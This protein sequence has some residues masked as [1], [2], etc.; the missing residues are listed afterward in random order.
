M[1]ETC[2]TC[3]FWLRDNQAFEGGSWR[4]CFRATSTDH[5]YEPRGRMFI[6]AVDDY[7][8]ALVTA[9]DFGCTEWRTIGDGIPVAIS[10]FGHLGFGYPG[11]TGQV[12]EPHEDR[13]P[14]PDYPADFT[15]VLERKVEIR[16]DA[17]RAWISVK[18]IGTELF[19]R[20]W[21]EAVQEAE[22][23]IERLTTSG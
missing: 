18:A 7:D 13:S 9:P 11:A 21:A 10:R 8:L 2:S 15:G 1:G 6:T 20:T 19:E 12:E 14:D 23:E 3:R 16:T 17:C 5:D 22:R 4:A